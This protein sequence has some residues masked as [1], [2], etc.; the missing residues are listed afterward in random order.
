MTSSEL[1][2][3]LQSVVDPELG[4]SIVELG[5]VYE[6]T[7]QEETKTAH[8]R[9]T[10]T[11]PTCPKQ[12]ELMQ[13]ITTALKTKWPAIQNVQIAFTFDPPWS[14][15]KASDDLKQQFA[16]LGIPLTR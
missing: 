3:A 6:A 2:D 4:F 8:V 14:P 12:D 15:E 9:M 13:A 16:L 7:W 11:T 10:L 5:L 1:R